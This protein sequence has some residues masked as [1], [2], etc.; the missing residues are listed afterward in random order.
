MKKVVFNISANGQKRLTDITASV[1]KVTIDA[2]N[3]KVTWEGS[4]PSVTFTVG[5]K[6]TYG[7]DGAE[8][9]GQLCFDSI[10]VLSDVADAPLAPVLKGIEV[11]DMT[12]EFKL[13]DSFKFDGKVVAYYYNQDPKEVQ[14]TSVDAPEMTAG[15]HTVE[16][17]YTE[18]DV[19][20]STSY[21]IVV[22]DPNATA[23]QEYTE[24]IVFSELGYSNG[25]EVPEVVSGDVKI[26]FDKGS[27]SNTSKYY[28][29]GTAVR[30][31]GGSFFTVTAGTTVTKIKFTFGSG[32][33]ANPNTL[34]ADSG[35]FSTD[36]WEGSSA[37]VKFTVGGTS[38]HRRI[39][40]VEV[41][42]EK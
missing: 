18:G 35:N 3:W 21:S 11:K 17:S 39:A 36:T 32:E 25:Q 20:L 22:K 34:T 40:A 9:N 4:A 19:T 5:E 26:V 6:A 42:Y 2:E 14:P 1:G 15:N 38:G 37:A 29:T 10:D 31:Y 33:G 23:G 7:T 41:T 30:S 27:N 8:K 24:K 16:V 12:T 13:G 28:N